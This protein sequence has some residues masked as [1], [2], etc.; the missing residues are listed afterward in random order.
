MNDSNGVCK[1]DWFAGLSEALDLVERCAKQI[2]TKTARADLVDLVLILRKRMTEG[3]VGNSG[4][5]AFVRTN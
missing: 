4:N 2:Q 1:D 3:M 5:A